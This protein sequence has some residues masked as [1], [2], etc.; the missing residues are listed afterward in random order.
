MIFTRV[1]LQNLY[2][3]NHAVLDLGIDRVNTLS[4]LERED[5]G[6]HLDNR[7]S[8][9]FKKVC[10]LTGGNASGKTAFSHVLLGINHFLM[11]GLLSQNLFRINHK[12]EPA[13]FD[14]N[15]AFPDQ[16]K[17]VRINVTISSP[18]GA[19]EP[20]IDYIKIAY[21][22]IRA[23][24]TC[25]SAT[26][27]L[28]DVFNHEGLIKGY[29]EFESRFT[30]NFMKFMGFSINTIHQRWHFIFSENEI[31]KTNELHLIRNDI[32]NTV[33]KTFDISIDKIIELSSLSESKDKK[34]SKVKAF[35]IL[36]TNGDSII[37]T[38]DGKLTEAKRLSRGTYE[39]IAVAH[40]L[41]NII[42]NK[43]DET[44]SGIYLSA[45]YFLDEGM[46]F[47]HT[48]L[49]RAILTLIIDSLPRYAQFFYTTHNHDII[50][51]NLPAHSF[52]FLK[53]DYTGSNFIEATS[54]FK[55]NDRRLINYVRNNEF[56]TAPEIDDIINYLLRR[57]NE[58]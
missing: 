33:L 54:K 38:A 20:F 44:T 28:D 50:E 22:N 52:T 41:S 13:S 36:F 32:L 9:R 48:E 42:T 18:A 3:F 6:E 21:V 53:K 39:A 46:A 40:F 11:F 56:E 17:L 35:E 8:F 26:K 55:K 45:I 23:N 7:P 24:D 25:N 30:E 19:D 51:M 37:L 27:R 4:T 58:K 15:I 12:D 1:I 47:A 31:E 16:E 5:G 57:N 2:C 49:E 14:I 43:E 34:P 29:T 10:I